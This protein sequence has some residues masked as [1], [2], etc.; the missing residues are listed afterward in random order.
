MCI[1]SGLSL[2]FLIF[3]FVRVKKKT[4]VVYEYIVVT[5]G[6]NSCEGAGDGASAC[7]RLCA[8]VRAPKEGTKE[9]GGKKKEKERR[10][11]RG[12]N[13]EEQV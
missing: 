6:L 2:K 7:V 10:E 1:P 12:R 13:E 8:C 11:V 3:S 4:C 9:R 5:L